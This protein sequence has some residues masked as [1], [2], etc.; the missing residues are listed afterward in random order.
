MLTMKVLCLLL[1]HLVFVTPDEKI[2][3]DPD[4]NGYSIITCGAPG[5]DGPPGLRGPNGEKGEK[6]DPGLPGPPGKNGKPGSNGEQGPPG[7]QGDRG[8]PG[9][10]GEQGI[11]G[12]PG[13]KG[14]TGAPGTPGTPGVAGPEGAKG[15]KG[16]IGPP[17]PPGPQGERGESALP[18]IESIKL[19]VTALDGRLRDLQAI[20]EKQGNAFAFLKGG[21]R[22]GNKIYIYND[23]EMTYFDAKAIC[24]KA[25]GQLASP[26]NDAENEAIFSIRK[27][28]NRH[29]FM[30]INDMQTEGTFRYP[31]GDVISYTNWGPNE[32]NNVD[33]KEH[34]VEIR[35]TGKWN[36]ENCAEKRHSVCEF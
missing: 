28:N 22:Y 34:C 7:P 29:A 33:G 4:K 12:P 2:C 13:E 36:D 14:E 20:V 1:L 35:D 31:S 6:G 21:A 16:D 19:Q 25:G 10:P 26:R 17:G 3:L 30:G 24:T 23:K 11:V 9:P 32:P 18:V 27:Q 8:L 15:E 5:R